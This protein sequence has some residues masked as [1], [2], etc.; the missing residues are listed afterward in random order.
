M[1][2]TAFIVTGRMYNFVKSSLVL[3]RRT[4]ELKL[5]NCLIKAIMNEKQLCSCSSYLK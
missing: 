4:D 5:L 2:F 3:T 1:Y